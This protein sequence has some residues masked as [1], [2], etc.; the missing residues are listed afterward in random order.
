MTRFSRTLA[1][2][3]FS[4]FF[5]PAI[6]FPCACGCNVFSV[7]SPLLMP[8]SSGLGF[9]LHYNYMDQGRNWGSWS[10]APVESNNDRE[11]RTSF[12]TLSVQDMIDREWGVMVEAPVW[13][14]YFRTIDD[15]GT[16]GSVDHTSFGDVRLTGMYTGLSEDMSIGLQFGLKLPTGSFHQSLLDRDTQVGT[17][18]T[19][20]LL[21][22]YWM[23]QEDGWG[24]YGQ[25]M[26]QR[27][28]SEREGYRP[29]DSF[30]MNIGVHYDDLLNTLPIVPSLQ[31]VGSFRSIDSGPNADPPNTG[32][33]RL[34]ISP[35][36]ELVTGSPVNIYA[37]VRIPLVTHV[38]GYQL[39]APA[40]YSVTVGVSI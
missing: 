24:W 32:Y 10:G 36:I 38:R 11:I 39:V 14:R 22:G 12:Y 13:D 27:A 6:A 3:A 2:S 23:R 30:D 28:L 21:G 18:T 29:G 26:W 15:N 4:L 25:V 31:L 5:L 7:G 8:I 9:Y 35:G 1:A 20:L 34:Y 40:L 16:A 33:Q 17:G 19:D 37:D